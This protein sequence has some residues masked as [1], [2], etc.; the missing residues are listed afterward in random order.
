MGQ[1]YGLPR[2]ILDIIR[3]HHGTSLV[4]YF[5]FKALKAEGPE[6]IKEEDFRYDGP[7]PS[8][9]ESA[10]VMLADTIEAAV[11]SMLGSGKT[12]AE[13][14]EAVK[15][16]MKDKLDDGQLNNSGLAIH[17]LEI[18]R[19]AFL[20]VFHGMYHERVAYPKKEEIEAAAKK[21]PP[22]QKEKQNV[23]IWI[24][25]RAGEIFPPELE[26]AVKKA[27]A[28]ALRCESFDEA[29]EISVSIVDN[30]EIRQ[31]NKQFREIDRATDVLS[32]PMLTFA[33]GEEPD[34]N[35]NGEILL[36]DIIISLERAKEQAAEYGHSLQREIAFL[37]AHSMLHLL[38]YDHIEPEEEAEMFRRQREILLLAGF[39]RE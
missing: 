31:I 13:A 22:E 15:G 3:Q 20:K 30:D 33:K 28:E 27:A 10:V 23:T 34:R 37:T 4:K 7:V 38:G 6:H 24:D 5:Y 29:C 9:R 32:F 35:E 21:N 2:T 1:A 17:E 39:P 18:I 26:N 12:L 8:F 19:G 25:N 36:G 16:L 11:R 14:E